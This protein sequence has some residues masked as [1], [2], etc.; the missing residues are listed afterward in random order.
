M[1]NNLESKANPVKGILAKTI[2]AAALLAGVLTAEGCETI[3]AINFVT[4]FSGGYHCPRE[5]GYR[6]CGL[7]DYVEGAED[8]CPDYRGTGY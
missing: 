5:N 1:K 2:L 4:S 6:C 3:D 7:W 8:Y